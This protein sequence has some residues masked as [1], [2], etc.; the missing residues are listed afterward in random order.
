MLCDIIYI[1]KHFLYI[2]FIID[3]KLKEQI[4]MIR[5]I[6]IDFVFIMISVLLFWETCEKIGIIFPIIIFLILMAFC[7]RYFSQR[8]SKLYFYIIMIILFI[9]VVGIYKYSVLRIWKEKYDIEF[10][11]A[12]FLIY[13]FEA[14]KFLKED[15]IS[16][17]TK[18]N[19]FR[20]RKEDLKRIKEYLLSFDMIGIN[21]EWGS[22]KTY[23]M[24]CLQNDKEM[25]NKYEFVNIYLLSCNLDN[26]PQI[27]INE[28]EK[29]LVKHGVYSR[30]SNS[31]RK[32]LASNILL[33]S[34]FGSIFLDT[35]S[36]T[37][38]IKGFKYEIERLD[39][40]LIIVFED[41]DRIDN[42]EIIKKI[43]SI[44]ENLVGNN[45]KVIYQYDQYNLEN[46]DKCFN[47]H[48]LD[49]YIPYVVNLT[50]ISFYNT[51]NKVLKE[52][53]NEYEYVKDSDFTFLHINIC[54]N[55]YLK[56]LFNKE[57]N[58]KLTVNN[59]SVRKVKHFLDE[60]EKTFESEEL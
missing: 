40:T 26:L 35:N 21:G 29:V 32:I 6:L 41:L 7:L 8:N 31:L 42:A 58:Y 30:Y 60:I 23:L 13:F 57:I 15:K 52:Y 38:S 4:I 24:Q 49:K 12:L 44:A 25:K 36:F 47:R 48:Y 55:W 14:L 2:R 20:E 34:V 59:Y 17:N 51:A 1:T 28:L 56:T 37:D 27:L 22:G 16:S 54:M 50:P 53:Q 9:I 3:D 5:K 45:I 11:V 33:N 46:I 39:K 43:F 19:L 10:F 18:E